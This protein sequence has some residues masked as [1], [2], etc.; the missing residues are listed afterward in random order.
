MFHELL[1]K[2]ERWISYNRFHIEARLTFHQ[3]INPALRTLTTIGVQIGRPDSV[4]MGSQ[5]I[6][7]T[8]AT[9][10]GFPNVVGE[11]LDTQERLYR[12]V[13]RLVK[14]VLTLTQRV[15]LHLTAMI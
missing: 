11:L 13:W 5:D 1:S 15:T 10:C 7:D 12:H 2:L 3:E 6:S 9:A 14:V 8:T 4:S